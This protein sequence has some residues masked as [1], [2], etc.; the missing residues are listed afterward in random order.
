MKLTFGLLA[1]AAICFA[2]LM[3]LG[4]AS[5]GV[6]M[7]GLMIVVALIVLAAIAAVVDIKNEPVI[8]ADRDRI[9][10]GYRLQQAFV[11]GS[12]RVVAFADQGRIV[13]TSS[14]HRR[15]D[16]ILT[17]NGGWARHYDD[18]YWTK[19]EPGIDPRGDAA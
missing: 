3:C 18:D 13:G 15:P 7:L 8:D 6:N 9:E 17:P 12:D 19:Q 4:D 1:A 2:V 16:M 14:P 10:K 11:D 5:V